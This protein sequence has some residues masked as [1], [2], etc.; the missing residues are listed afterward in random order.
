MR[1][2]TIVLAFIAFA[3]HANDPDAFIPDR[4]TLSVVS[5]EE[6]SY[7]PYGLAIT[8]RC[9]VPDPCWK[10]DG[11]SVIN[12]DSTVVGTVYGRPKG[13]VPCPASPSFLDVTVE[14]PGSVPGWYTFQFWHDSTTTVDTIFFYDP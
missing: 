13:Y 9:A 8:V 6:I 2:F 7:L 14:W 3:C 12:D 5:Y 11:A 1:S 10:F 4:Q